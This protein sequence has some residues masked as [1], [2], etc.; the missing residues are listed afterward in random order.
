[1]DYVYIIF[2]EQIFCILSWKEERFCA[3]IVMF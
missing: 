3:V 1:M 2:K